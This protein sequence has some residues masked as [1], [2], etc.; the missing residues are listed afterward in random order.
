[1]RTFPW[2]FMVVP[3]SARYTQ[4]KEKSLYSISPAHSNDAE[5]DK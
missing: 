4:G 5:A 2:A 3:Y 1:M